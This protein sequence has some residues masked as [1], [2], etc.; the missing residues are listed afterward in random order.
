ML[1]DHV[2]RHKYLR[3]LSDLWYALIALPS[4]KHRVSQIFVTVY[5]LLCTP[6]G[7]I[8]RETRHQFIAHPPNYSEAMLQSHCCT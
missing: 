4:I 7:E 8:K 1:H 3:S 6:Y 2:L 5:E